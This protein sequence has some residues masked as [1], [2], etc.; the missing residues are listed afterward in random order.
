M[1]IHTGPWPIA[2]VLCGGYS[3]AKITCEQC[4]RAYHHGCFIS[5]EC[6]REK[7]KTQLQALNWA[8]KKI[9]GE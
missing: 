2:C 1:T 7:I 8:L 6:E 4:G 9:Y 5:H 3:G